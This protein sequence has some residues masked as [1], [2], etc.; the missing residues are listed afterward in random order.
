MPVLRWSL[1][2]VTLRS[3]AFTSGKIAMKGRIR[4]RKRTSR[5]REIDSRAKEWTY[6]PLAGNTSVRRA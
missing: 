1:A 2:C 4:F 3:G 6:I 5:I